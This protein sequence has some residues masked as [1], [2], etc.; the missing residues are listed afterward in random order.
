M[1]KAGQKKKGETPAVLRC[2]KLATFMNPGKERDLRA[3]MRDWREAAGVYSRLQWRCFH[4]DGRFDPYL[5]P[6]TQ[7][8]KDG[9]KVG[10]EPSAGSHC[11]TGSKSSSRR[12]QKNGLSRRKK[13]YPRRLA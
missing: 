10:L 9:G 11:G 7:Y 13:F 2:D 5:D 8:R 3:M 6:A 12:R 1:A 4:Q